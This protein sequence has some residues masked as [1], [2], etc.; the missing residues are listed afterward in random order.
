LKI[1]GFLNSVQLAF[2]MFPTEGRKSP[3]FFVRRILGLTTN[4]AM[5]RTDSR[6]ERL[7]VCPVLA[8][9]E[10]APSV[11]LVPAVLRCGNAAA[12]GVSQAL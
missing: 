4:A 9:R 6:S 8:D 11:A 12:V 3:K 2:T 5:G 10:R 7:L 1:N